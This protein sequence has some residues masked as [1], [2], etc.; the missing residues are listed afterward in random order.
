MSL[1]RPRGS[2]ASVGAV[3]HGSGFHGNDNV[4]KSTRRRSCGRG[5]TVGVV[6]SAGGC[7]GGSIEGNNE[8]NTGG[9]VEVPPYAEMVGLLSSSHFNP[10]P[11]PLLSPSA[12]PISPFLCLSHSLPHTYSAPLYSLSSSSSPYRT[13][14]LT[15][16]A[17][18]QTAPALTR[19]QSEATPSRKMRRATKQT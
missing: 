2:C 15:W 6:G 18:Y 11:L 9:S 10:S 3:G 14:E 19:T 16:P 1:H 13:L 8:C 4:G 7:A 12:L 5:S 17:Q